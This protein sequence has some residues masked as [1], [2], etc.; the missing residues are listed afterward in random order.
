M[1]SMHSALLMVLLGSATAFAAASTPAPAPAH[2]SGKG[3]LG[4]LASQGNTQ[5]KSANALIDLSYRSGLWKHSL[6]LTTLYGESLGIVSAERWSALWQ[7]NRKISADAYAFGSLRYEH[8]LFNGFQYQGSGALGVGYTLIH[9]K[10]TTLSTQVGAGYMVSRPETL[11]SMALTNPTRTFIE[12]IPQLT[13][14]YAI[15]TLGVNYE[16]TITATTSLSDKLLVNAGSVN[17]LVTNDVALTVK[18]STQLALSLGY[19][20]QDNTHPA[21]GI[22]HLDSTET[23]NLVY[24][25]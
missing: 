21:A 8:D 7:S 22:Q 14:R 9:S 4:F 12:R 20:I 10:T 23:V 1:K 2:F 16:H 13:Q 17:T 6:D 25:F 19:N 18:V 3:Q 5:G 11:T 15:G 24:A